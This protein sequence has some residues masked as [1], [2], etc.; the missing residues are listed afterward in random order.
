M[1]IPLATGSREHD[2]KR[3]PGSERWRH[4]RGHVMR[5]TLHEA[6]VLF[7][8]LTTPFFFVCLRV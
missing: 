1:R 5:P 7:E 4:V 3:I 8:A 6:V 2:A